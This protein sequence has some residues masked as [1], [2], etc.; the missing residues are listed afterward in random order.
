[1]DYGNR[2]M[3][4]ARLLRLESKTS[5]FQAGNLEI[6]FFIVLGQNQKTFHRGLKPAVISPRL[7]K[8]MC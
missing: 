3:K 5:S 8:L 4:L 7:P 6:Q 1:M 2:P